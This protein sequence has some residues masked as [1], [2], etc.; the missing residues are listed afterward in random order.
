MAEDAVREKNAE[1]TALAKKK[2]LLLA[3]VRLNLSH[4]IYRTGKPSSI[5][6]GV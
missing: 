6:I 5:L 4:C 3:S 1:L 2:S